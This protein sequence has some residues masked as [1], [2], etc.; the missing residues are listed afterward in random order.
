MNGAVTVDRMDI[1]DIT[2]A[3]LIEL[4]RQSIDQREAGFDPNVPQWA[5]DLRIE[6]H[7]AIVREMIRRG[8]L[9][10]ADRS[11]PSSTAA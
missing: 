11:R 1:R 3:A 5:R 8:L 10:Q 9:G 6:R 4:H 2:N 7:E